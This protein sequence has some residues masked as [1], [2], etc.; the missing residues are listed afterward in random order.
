MGWTNQVVQLVI[1][2]AGGAFTGLFLYSQTV[3]AGHLIASIAA[4]SGTDPYGNA[5]ESGLTTYGADGSIVRQYEGAYSSP[6]LDIAASAFTTYLPPAQI[7]AAYIPGVVL[8]ES[9]AGGNATLVLAAPAD[10]NTVNDVQALMLL[11]NRG[12]TGSAIVD[13]DADELLADCATI[14]LNGIVSSAGALEESAVETDSGTVTSTTYTGARTGTTNVAGCAFIAPTSGKIKIS[15]HA[16]VSNSSTTAFTLI[17]FEVRQGSTV[18]SGTVIVTASDNVCI[19]HSGTTAEESKSTFYP[20][21]AG[22]LVAGTQYNVRLMYRVSAGTGTINRPR[23][24]AE[25]I[26]G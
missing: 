20:L 11:S 26:L 4:S 21:D 17:S 18:G 25:P 7:G 8:A 23:V 24:M 22:Q 9:E 3:G 13:F 14:A 10:G 5:Y 1:I 15:W 19:Q 16:G 12:N 2:Q 6:N